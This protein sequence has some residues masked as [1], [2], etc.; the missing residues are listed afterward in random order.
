V[1]FRHPRHRR[2]DLHG[3]PRRRDVGAAGADQERAAHRAAASRATT[4]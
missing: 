3:E 4:R 2:G 1:L